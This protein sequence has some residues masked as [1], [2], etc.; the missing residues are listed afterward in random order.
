MIK[1]MT[2]F[3]RYESES[4]DM[5]LSIEI[6][7]VNHKYIDY[8][9]RMP[10]YL[11]FL[12]DKIK[13]TI[14]NY[15]SRGRVEVYIK[16][17]RKFNSASKVELDLPLAKSIN[18]SLNDLIKELN[19]NDEVQLNNLL[20]YDDILTLKYD[21]IDEEE[22]SNLVIQTLDKALLNL[23]DMR[24][25]EGDRLREDMNT[26]LKEIKLYLEKIETRSPKLVEEYRNRLNESIDNLIDNSDTYDKDRLNLEVVIYAEKSD[27]NEEIVRLK[28]HI[29]SFEDTLLI[30]TPVGR[31][32][33]FIVQEM[34]REINTIS[35][36]SNDSCLTKY[37][38]EV[39]SLIEKIRE[40]IQNIE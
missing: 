31:K 40:Q 19:I 27:I 30:E 23:L 14:K 10:N 35:S 6:K 11:N 8:Q 18:K 2:G 16:V 36:K 9:I 21:D 1:S 3:G 24:I 38:I 32:L 20:K 7:T 5:S 39:K 28:S 4:D 17:D 37:V 12:E 26:N 33:D 13:K 34:N 29:K 25:A 15:L 22:V